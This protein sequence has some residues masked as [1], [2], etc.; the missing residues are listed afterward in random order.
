MISKEIFNKIGWRLN[1]IARVIDAS[2]Q[3][4]KQKGFLFDKLGSCGECGY[5]IV[6]DYHRKKKS[7]LEFRYYRCS[8][9]S[10]TCR[11][12]EKAIN[13]KDLVPQ[14]EGLVSEIAINDDW[15]QW[16]MDTITS[17]KNDEEGT[18]NEQITILNSSVFNMPHS[19]T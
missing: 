6:H 7:G 19:H 5:S 2:Q 16:S 3:R 17:W 10:P 12:Q 11:C 1:M 18:A 13:E 14:I 9:K 4:K 15:Y 8:K